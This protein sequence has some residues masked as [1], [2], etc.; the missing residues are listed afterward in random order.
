MRQLEKINKSE[1]DSREYYYTEL[2]N[3]LKVIIIEDINASMCSALL[4]INVGSVNE[5]IEGLAH[6]LEHMVFMGSSKYP[7]ES[8]F[9]DFVSKN[10]GIT[11]ASTSDSDTT[12]Y[13]IINDSKFLNI[14]DMFS[15]FFI[16]PL[17]KQDG[18]EREVNAVD[19][20]SKKNLLDDGWIFYEVFKK[21]MSDVHPINHYTCG[22]NLTLKGD[23][24]RDK[25]KE[26]FDRYYS[27]NLMNLIIFKN[28]KINLETLLKQ[29]NE[30]FGKI[31]N[32]NVVINRNYGNILEPL[33][34]IKYNPNKSNDKLYICTQIPK[35]K[36]YIN[37][38]AHF[39]H[40][41]LLSKVDNSLYKILYDKFEIEDIEFNEF[42]SF[43]DYTIYMCE[44][45]L[46][47][48]N[49]IAYTD[50]EI[51]E[52]VKIFFDYLNSIKNTN[53]DKL[54]E[55]YDK[56]I[57]KIK[58]N[59]I[60][61]TNLNYIDTMFYFNE[62]LS[63][64]INPI[65]LLDYNLHKKNYN[66]IKNDINNFII[67]YNTSNT[68]IIYATNNISI[69]NP[70]KVNR[71]NTKYSIERIEPFELISNKYEIIKSN[72]YITDKIILIKGED[73]YPLKHPE[74]IEDKYKLIYNFN[75]S[76]KTPYV[77]TYI[78]I[79]VP[80]ITS[81]IDIFTKSL[82]YINTIEANNTNII[83]ELN[84]ASYNITIR[85]NMNRI[86][87]LIISDNLNID[88]IYL[89]FNKIF[90]DESDSKYNNIYNFLYNIFTNFKK[91]KPIIK[92]EHLTNK[93]LLNNYY[94]P[95]EILS[96]LDN[97]FTF[98]DCKNTFRQ[99][100]NKALVKIFISGN[101]E[102]DKVLI[103]SKKLFEYLNI[104]ETIAKIDSNINK[105]TTP[106]IKKYKNKSNDEQNN[107]FS[108]I[109]KFTY[110]E[111]GKGEWKKYISFVNILESITGSLYFNILRTSEQLGYIVQSRI[112]KLGNN[113]H[114]I[115]GIKFV[116][117]S[118]KKNSE[119]I[120]NRTLNF[121]NNELKNYIDKLTEEEF[122]E[123]KEGEIAGL[124]DNFPNILEL[125]SY[126]Y[127]HINDD[128]YIY[129]YKKNIINEL[130][131]FTLDEFK[132]MFLKHMI[133]FP[134]YYSISIDS[135]KT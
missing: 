69:K 47:N 122:N 51:T 2:E 132:E 108:L 17:L 110:L 54:N 106:I 4:N 117:Q 55:L 94:T 3:K 76:F 7:D 113:N 1:N 73:T 114:S 53:S 101:I 89:I 134:H 9:M 59:F 90:N 88:E 6:F 81:N 93:I 62:K 129:D 84:G 14:L 22:D 70:L 64:N 31:K 19:S 57:M 10:G 49:N 65:N 112:I 128:S 75:S 18:I 109:Y 60:I 41:I 50:E 104:K 97:K 86:F 105:I 27:S 133:K 42:I 100:L 71:F 91:D 56:L 44:I 118:Y 63:K 120:Y 36:D 135:N 66:D 119:Y 21:T 35:Y 37:S 99:T 40:N 33:N 25:V 96:S 8:N 72:K 92:L 61:P 16:D 28:N 29:I 15:W 13:F 24:L 102:K 78:I 20:E 123:Y 124:I 46:K 11:N 98:D 79:D 77:Y 12:Y 82:L 34:I 30:T 80:E 48:R 67:K 43:D 58:R 115:Y 127:S 87:I 130:L 126:L 131:I 111:K 125:N 74:V 107:I 38:P 85:L 116:V 5:E 32:H 23:D 68:S 121:V 39:I 26:F 45:S 103:L 83:N 52:M 95:Y